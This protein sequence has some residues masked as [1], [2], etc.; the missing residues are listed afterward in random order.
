[1]TPAGLWRRLAVMLYDALLLLAL[2][3]GATFALL[4]F[5]GGEAVRNQLLMQLWVLAIAF[6]FFGWFWTHGGQ[7][8]GMK[9]WRVR[10]VRGDGAALG[11]RD[12]LNRFAF[13]IPSLGLG[14]FG[15]WWMLF[16]RERLALHDRL[17]GTRVVVVPKP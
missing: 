4:P 8:L 17:S 1:M 7:T 2:L 13:A 14:G 11:W 16:D 9:A 10:V 5:T 15:L 3:M 12:A 6:V